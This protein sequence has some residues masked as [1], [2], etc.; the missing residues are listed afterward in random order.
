MRNTNNAIKEVGSAAM[1][2]PH[3]DGSFDPVLTDKDLLKCGWRWM[4]ASLTYNY[5]TQQSG[6]VA[7]A[8]RDA[9]KKIY[10]GDGTGY[11]ASVENS[12]K[13]FNITPHMGGLVLG[14]ALAVE[15]SGH[16]ESIEAARDLKIGLMGPLSGVGDTVFA[17]LIPTI[18]GSIAAYMGQ[19]GNTFGM[20]LWLALNIVIYLLVVNSWKIGYQF[21]TALITSLSDRISIFTEA[22]SVLGLTVVGALIATVVKIQTGLSFAMGDVVMNIQ[23]DVLDPIMLC[24]L[25]VAVTVIVYFLVKK[26]INM[27][28]IILGIIAVSCLCAATGILV[29]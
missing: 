23:S 8:E 19:S 9:L 17:I 24:L 5:E 4:I 6:S 12:F 16:A 25:P 15:D 20:F 27:N 1:P 14:A 3:A 11:L 7:L 13:Y 22:A 29:P 26:H 10:A 2:T 18:M 21:G 28:A